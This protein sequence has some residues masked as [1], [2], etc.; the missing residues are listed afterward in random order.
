MNDLIHVL[1]SFPYL[2]SRVYHVR[3]K[4]AA[5]RD[6]C[7]SSR[8]SAVIIPY[9]Y[10]KIYIFFLIAILPGSAYN[11]IEFYLFNGITNEEN[12]MKYTLGI[13]IGSTTVKIAVLDKEHRLLFSDY[14]RHFAN[15][16]ETLAALLDKSLQPDRRPYRPSGHHGI[17]GLALAN[18]LKIPFVQEVIA[19]S[20]FCRSW[21]LRQMSESNLAVKTPRL[22]ILREVPLSSV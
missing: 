2:F 6:I 9:F 13:D 5:R 11:I 7:F 10:Q 1:N 12:K 4:Q 21:R 14:E 8:G 16:Q 20:S 19:V 15:I 3:K 18:H 17:R 22:F